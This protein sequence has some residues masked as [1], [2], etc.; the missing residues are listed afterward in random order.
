MSKSTLTILSLVLVAG[1]AAFFAFRVFGD[2][3]E[4]E[5][6]K[7]GASLPA[8][9]AEPPAPVVPAGKELIYNFDQ[10][11]AGKLPANFHSALTGGGPQ[12]QWVV[13]SD[14]SAPSGRNVLA[15]TSRDQ[16]DY[17]FPLVIADEGLFRDLIL[18]VK[19]KALDGTV[20]RA[21]G[22]AFRLRDANNYYVPRANAL[23][24]NYNLYHVVRGVR[25]EITGTRLKVTSREWHEI[26]VEAVGNK[27]TCS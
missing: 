7:P 1:V 12:P 9:A 6:E 17:R 18:S 22:L 8:A 14:Q 2:R 26:R 4:D 23:E 20:D 25:R 27:I 16:T 11:E 13:Q 15:Q 24:D 19:F 21:A 5:D 10:D 3:D